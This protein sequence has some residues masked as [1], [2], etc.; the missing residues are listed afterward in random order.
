M[1]GEYRKVTKAERFMQ[2]TVEYTKRIEEMKYPSE[3]SVDP[4]TC[5]ANSNIIWYT[6]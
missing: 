4:I 5:Y 6:Y 2:R 1:A 3:L